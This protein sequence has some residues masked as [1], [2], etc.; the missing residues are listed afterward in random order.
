MTHRVAQIKAAYYTDM[1]YAEME[2][3]ATRLIAR[4][5]RLKYDDETIEE[6]TKDKATPEKEAKKKRQEK[7]RSG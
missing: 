6:L 1:I 2:T 3:E 5:L 7:R 4:M